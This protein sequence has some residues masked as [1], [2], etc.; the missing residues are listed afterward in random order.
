MK[1]YLSFLSGPSSTGVVG[2]M[3]DDESF[4]FMA[5][6]IRELQLVDDEA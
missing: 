1:T 3:P 2:S 4:R 5:N 6:F